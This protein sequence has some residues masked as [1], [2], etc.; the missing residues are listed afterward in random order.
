M[1]AG[2]LPAR[3]RFPM[4]LRRLYLVLAALL[5]SLP[6]LA[7]SVAERSPFAQGHWWNPQRAGTG[8]DIFNTNGTVAFVWYAYDEAGRP[9]WYNAIGAQADLGKVAF[10]LWRE[11]WSGGRWSGYAGGGSGQ[12]N[13]RHAESI[14]L[15]WAIG[16]KRG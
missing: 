6:A 11:R 1:Q 13:G 14:H 10:P 8:F 4:L 7:V 15:D 5:V 16:G 9:V 3:W 2:A 12:L